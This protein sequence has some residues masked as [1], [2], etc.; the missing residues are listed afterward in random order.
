MFIGEVVRCCCVAMFVILPRS[1]LYLTM[2]VV[3][4]YAG[5]TAKGACR[6][7]GNSWLNTCMYA[8]SLIRRSVGLSKFLW[9]EGHAQ[10][11]G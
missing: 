5:Q 9:L 8:Y 1:W 10:K 6:Q 4:E 7:D 2:L 11:V 3:F